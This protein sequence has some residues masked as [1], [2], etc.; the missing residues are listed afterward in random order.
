M[1]TCDRGPIRR[2]DGSIKSESVNGRLFPAA[3][4]IARASGKRSAN[5]VARS[6]S[7]CP[8][9]KGNGNCQLE[10]TVEPPIPTVY[11]LM[12]AL[13]SRTE[14]MRLR[15]ISAMNESVTAVATPLRFGCPVP[16]CARQTLSAAK[17]RAERVTLS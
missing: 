6:G 7:L 11:P 1:K 10:R 17:E 12:Y 15:A 2:R 8:S 13:D 3:R 9:C 16:Q 4:S 5:L 14:A